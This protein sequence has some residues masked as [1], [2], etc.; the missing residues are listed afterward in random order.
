MFARVFPTEFD[1]WT[2]GMD[3]ESRPLSRMSS[4][5]PFPEGL[6]R[7]TWQRKGKLFSRSYYSPL[8]PNLPPSSSL[9]PIS[10]LGHI[11]LVIWHQNSRFSGLCA[12]G[13]KL[14]PPLPVFWVHLLRATAVWL[15]CSRAQI[16]FSPLGLLLSKQ[17]CRNLKPKSN[18]FSFFC[19]GWESS[20]I[21]EVFCRS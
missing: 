21:Q 2:N 6:V 14:I 19:F 5:H 17:I 13:L 4:H 3:T 12:L 16:Y 10:E 9:S 1:S 11:F 15:L 18:H 8:P 7:A 20:K